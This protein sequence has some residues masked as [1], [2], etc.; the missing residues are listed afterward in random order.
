MDQ[1]TLL[2]AIM[3][4]EFDQGHWVTLAG[5]NIRNTYGEEAIRDRNCSK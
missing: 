3:L 2:R 1:Q 5:K 4:Y